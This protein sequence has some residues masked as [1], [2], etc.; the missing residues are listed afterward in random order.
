MTFLRTRLLSASL[1]LVALVPV[2]GMAATDQLAPGRI[3]WAACTD[4]LV[5]AEWRD[6]W[7]P[8][9]QCGTLSVPRAYGAPESGAVDI[10][11]VRVR[12]GE[13]SQRQGTIFFHFGGPGANPLDF[14]PQVAATWALASPDS[15]IDGDKRRLADRYDLL[16]I[17]PRGLRGGP[18]VTCGTP[19]GF[20]GGPDPTIDLADW[21]WSAFVREAR[22]FATACSADAVQSTVNTHTHVLDM[23]KVRRSLGEPTVHFLGV[24]YGSWVGAFYAALFPGNAG[25]M[26]LDSSMDYT[27]T[28]EQQIDSLAPET[29][30]LLLRRAVRPALRDPAYGWRERTEASVLDAI[31]AVP[32][33][34]LRAWLGGIETPDELVAML[35]LA[36]WIR[37]VRATWT[38]AERWADV[39]AQLTRRARDHVFSPDAATDARVRDAAAELIDRLDSPQAPSS[40]T[41]MAV[42]FG[43]TCGDGRWTKDLKQLRHLAG[44]LGQRYPLHGGGPVLTGLICRFWPHAPRLTIPTQRLAES[45]PPILMVHAEF[46]VITPIDG[47]LRAFEGTRDARMVVAQG[48]VGHGVFGMSDTPCVEHT[49][50]R[51]LLTGT[52]PD[53]RVTACPFVPRAAGREERAAD[54]WPSLDSIR[55]TLRERLRRS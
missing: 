28:F 26:V 35:S 41:D 23:E 4:D 2:A 42:Y 39:P 51:F 45:V 36:E 46:D 29:H 9:L 8:R 10:G 18:R 43:T 13:M 31:R 40:M 47:A 3:T 30:D 50:G 32:G 7:G 34:A 44:V 11:L 17:V 21:N 49:V 48:M 14:L 16:A 53:E 12:A 15:A 1:T 55:E 54:G 37:E 22:E 19:P 20:S 33:E 25:R 24:S 38:D 27:G 6:A 5:D 52:L